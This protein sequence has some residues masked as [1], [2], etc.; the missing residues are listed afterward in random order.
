MFNHPVIDT[1]EKIQSWDQLFLSMAYVLGMKSKDRSGVGCIVTDSDHRVLSVGFNGFPR[2]VQ[3]L[4]ERYAD[5]ETKHAMIVHAEKNAIY[6][7]A[8]S[9]VQL[10]GSI[11][12][13]THPPCGD[14]TAAIIQAGICRVIWPQVNQFEAD[15]DKQRWWPENTGIFT[16]AKESRQGLILER[17]P[18][19]IGF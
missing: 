5:S 8:Y 17:C 18:N 3:D 10:Q 15:M 11:L 16:L 2:G 6:A 7:A 14:C 13:C 1:G 12:Y 19:K 9:G 4:P